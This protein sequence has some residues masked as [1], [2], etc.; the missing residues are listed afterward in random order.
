MNTGDATIGNSFLP[1]ATSLVY[2]IPTVGPEAGGADLMVC[3]DTYVVNAS[4]SCA[5]AVHVF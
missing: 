4:R 3:P 5:A 2:R 1:H